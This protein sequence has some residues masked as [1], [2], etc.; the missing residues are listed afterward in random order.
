MD[1][2]AT[3]NL[4]PA[5]QTTSTYVR[6]HMCIFCDYPILPET[7]VRL[8][9]IDQSPRKGYNVFAHPH[10]LPALHRWRAEGPAT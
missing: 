6:P 10:C 5:T 4:T 9:G 1:H 3:H 8:P 2:H 7:T